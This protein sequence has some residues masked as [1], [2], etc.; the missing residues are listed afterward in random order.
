MEVSTDSESSSFRAT[1]LILGVVALTITS[2]NTVEAP[3]VDYEPLKTINTFGHGPTSILMNNTTIIIEGGICSCGTSGYHRQGT[4]TFKN[5][6][7]FCTGKLII[8]SGWYKGTR[9]DE[10]E[11]SCT[12]CGADY[13]LTDGW[14]KS[15]TFRKQLERV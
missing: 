11:A 10:F 12:S 13:C 5:Q 9:I 3:I 14:E 8:H 2:S 15:G 7:T 6:C 4:I 1:L